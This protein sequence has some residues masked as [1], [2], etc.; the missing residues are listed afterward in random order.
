MQEDNALEQLQSHLVITP[1]DTDRKYFRV[2]IRA[3]EARDK[4][5]EDLKRIV[6]SYKRG[7]PY[8]DHMLKRIDNA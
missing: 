8:R 3:I 7:Y 4:E 5:I 2:A 6:E 1:F